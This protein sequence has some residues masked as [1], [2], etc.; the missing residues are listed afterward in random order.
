MKD[1]GLAV[2]GFLLPTLALACT[3]CCLIF[4]VWV[5]GVLYD[6][7]GTDPGF[8]SYGLGAPFRDFPV[9][10]FILVIVVSALGVSAIFVPRLS[11][12]FSRRS[13]LLI[14]VSVAILIICCVG[15]YVFSQ[16]STRRLSP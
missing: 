3:A 11:S 7:E 15:V 5:Y 16:V 13:G 4:P 6:R 12:F 1:I 14:A 9:L 8:F 10:S 2:A